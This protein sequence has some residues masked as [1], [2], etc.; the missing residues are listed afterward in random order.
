MEYR[1]TVGDAV[2]AELARAGVDT[3]FGII[4]I[5]NIPIYDA[6]S[7]HGGFRVV[8]PRGESGAVNMADAYARVGGRLGVAITSTGTGAGNAAG[9]LIEAETAGTPLLH[10]TGQVPSEHIDSGRGYIHECRDQLSML[11]SISKQAHRIRRP[12]QASSTTRLAIGQALEAPTG[13]VSVEIPIDY[14]SRLI[15]SSKI[16]VSGAEPSVNEPPDVSAAVKEILKS[17]RPVMW[18]GSGVFRGGGTCEFRRLVDLIDAAVI[19]SQGARGTLPET[20]PRCLGFFATDPDVRELLASADLLISVGT[21]FRGNETAYWDVGV[22]ANHIGIDIDPSAV[23]RNYPHS[24][25]LI[26]DSRPILSSLVTA[27][28]EQGGRTKPQYRREVLRVYEASRARMRETMGPYEA[29]L[30]AIRETLPE[31]GIV[32]RDVT[33][34]TTTWASRMIEV[35]EPRQTVH[36]ATIGIGQALPMAIGASIAMPG[37][38]ALVLSGDGGFLVNPGEMAVIAEEGL[39]FTIVV[40]DDGGY[41]VLRN[42]QNKV[43]DERRVGVDLKSPDFVGLAK[44]FGLEAV[45][46]GDGNQFRSALEKALESPHAWMIVV[47]ADQL[48]TTPRP[49]TGTPSLDLYR[50]K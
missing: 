17:E 33:I 13:P 39:S 43:F 18:A 41:G 10:I 29:I 36:A 2:V 12:E 4:S 37:V 20:D 27:L 3:V 44:A 35:T 24:M 45:R 47:D 6:L 19:T 5:H 40:F 11:K 32:V 7:R 21:R 34:P 48:G 30:D 1:I 38:A 28:D 8:K 25:A 26:G 50:P 23:N 9:A 22:P 16:A 31:G 49:F 15:A 14:Q 42:L 46:V